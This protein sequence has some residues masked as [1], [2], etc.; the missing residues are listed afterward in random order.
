[1]VAGEGGRWRWL[2][3][4]SRPWWSPSAG[5]D[6]GEVLQLE[7]ESREVM[8]NLV[9]EKGGTRVELTVRGGDGRSGGSNAA[10]RGGGLVTSADESHLLNYP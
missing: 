4:V 5:E 10:R 7:E 2:D 1:M 6:G 3:G 8:D 9:E